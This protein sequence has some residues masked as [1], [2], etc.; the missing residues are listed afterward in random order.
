[1][2]YYIKRINEGYYKLHIIG[3]LNHWVFTKEE[4]KLFNSVKDARKEIKKYN[5]KNCEVEK[6]GIK[7]NI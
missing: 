6:C 1:M 5:L 7:K 2:K 3:A 4:A